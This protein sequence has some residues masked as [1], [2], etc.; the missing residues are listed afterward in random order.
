[1]NGQRPLN[2]YF[3]ISQAPGTR[4]PNPT[5]IFLEKLLSIFGEEGGKAVCLLDLGLQVGKG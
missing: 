2:L 5:H 3:P 1:M 4:T